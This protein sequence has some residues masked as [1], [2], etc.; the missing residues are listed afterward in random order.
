MYCELCIQITSTADLSARQA[1]VLFTSLLQIW[2]DRT[3]SQWYKI[4]DTDQ[5]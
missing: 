2:Y 3:N 4:P 5:I 1:R